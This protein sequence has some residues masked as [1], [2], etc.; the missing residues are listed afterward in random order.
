MTHFSSEPT[1]GTP[2]PQAVVRLI[3]LLTVPALALDRTGKVIARNAHAGT[4]RAL[5]G[6]S[7]P[8]RDWHDLAARS[9]VF[10]ASA[11]FPQENATAPGARLSRFIADDSDAYVLFVGPEDKQRL[12]T[13]AVA[14]HDIRTELQSI[15]AA[16]SLLG[17]MPA[18]TEEGHTSYIQVIEQAAERATR[19][20]NDI[21]SFARAEHERL[22]AAEETFSPSERTAAT[23]HRLEPLATKNRTVIE[24]RRG[25]PARPVVGDANLVDTIVQNLLSNAVKFAPDGKVV[26]S[27]DEEA[28]DDGKSCNISITVRDNGTGIAD[29][30]KDHIF[31]PFRS[32]PAG[33]SDQPGI[34]IGAYAVNEAVQALNGTVEMDSTPG[35]GTCFSVE[36]SLPFAVPTQL[37][38]RPESNTDDDTTLLYG[39][40][41]LVV[42]DNSINLELL[43]KLL[44]SAGALVDHVSNGKDALE[45]IWAAG[46]EYDL[47]LTDLNM[48]GIDGYALVCR[49]LIAEREPL[50]PR[51]AALTGEPT[52]ECKA[53]CDALGIVAILEKPVR[54]SELRQRVH[55]IVNAAPPAASQ[56]QCDILNPA[57]TAELQEDFGKEKT[58]ELRHRALDEARS[59]HALICAHDPPRIDRSLI[60]SAVGSSGMTGLDRVEHALRVLQ[61]VSKVRDGGPALVAALDLLE[62]TITQTQA[63]LD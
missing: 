41:L 39:A 46:A 7:L 47:I 32:G 16:S 28:A 54:P 62:K 42:D 5:A 11:P 48:P 61:A 20:V 14:A 53:A 56:A 8:P 40:R 57:M 9:P 31:K 29:Q 36:F 49:L 37:D 26:L 51:I 50:L 25:L 63:Q 58:Y 3:E 24:V 44:S 17:E 33:A 59:L 6:M 1:V 23:A 10:P 4:R 55:D 60:H 2:P 21:L 19:L 38:S 30:E 45:R 27:V 12:H 22:A 52:E 13:L 18:E 35:E 34:G 15:M 43:L